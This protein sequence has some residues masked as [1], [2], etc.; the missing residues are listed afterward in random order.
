MEIIDIREAKTQRSSL[1]DK[2]AANGES[3]VIAKAD[4]PMAKVV[5]YT[6][7]SQSPRTG[8]L[9]GQIT[10]PKDFDTMHKKEI[11]E[12]FEQVNKI[13]LDAHFLH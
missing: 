3:F 13:P 10:V 9:K 6:E 2:V 11:A 5:P 8:F 1:V 7:P 12:W 4:K